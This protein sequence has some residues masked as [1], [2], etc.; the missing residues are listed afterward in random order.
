[1]R[2]RIR[3][4]C[5]GKYAAPF[6]GGGPEGGGE[7]SGVV[8]SLFFRSVGESRY[9]ATLRSKLHKRPHRRESAVRLLIRLA[10]ARH[11]PHWGGL[12]VY[13]S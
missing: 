13:D 2:R 4:H 10:F 1:M 5:I 9:Y 8:Y 7:G 6:G 12:S 11:L 3:R